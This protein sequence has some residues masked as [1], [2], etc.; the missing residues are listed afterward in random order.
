MTI[1]IAELLKEKNQNLSKFEQARNEKRFFDAVKSGNRDVVRQLVNKGVDINTKDGDGWTAL[2][3]ATYYG[4]GY[5]TVR[6]LTELGADLDIQNEDGETALICAIIGKATKSAKI[7]ISNGANVSIKD[8]NGRTALM[9]AIEG[10]LDEIKELLLP[11]GQEILKIERP[12]KVYIVG[13][14]NFHILSENNVAQVVVE[15]TEIFS[16]KTPRELYNE[17]WDFFNIEDY[18]KAM[19]CWEAAARHPDVDKKLKEEL[20]KLLNKKEINSIFPDSPNLSYSANRLT[21]GGHTPNM[22]YR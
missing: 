12:S 11:K 13:N 5:K 7:L 6:L 21:R 8:N 2:M 3:L 15:S 1:T 18:K 20:I 16:S 19:A 14:A 4:D 9:L 22:L 17:G 10:N